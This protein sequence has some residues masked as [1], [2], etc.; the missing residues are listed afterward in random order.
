MR[1]ASRRLLSASRTYRY[2]VD[3]L[4][5]IHHDD[6][7]GS[8]T[9]ATAQ[10]DRKFLDSLYRGLRRRVDGIWSMRCAGEVNMVELAADIKR[11]G[12]DI[13]VFHSLVDGNK[14]AFAG[15]LTEPFEPRR[16]RYCHDTG[17]LY[18]ELSG[19][20]ERFG[21]LGLVGGHVVGHDLAERLIFYGASAT[22]VE[23]DWE[24]ARHRVAPL[25]DCVS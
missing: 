21:R 18:H 22:S 8:R 6:Q 25:V 20:N 9:L 13:V 5:Q 17:H 11:K 16:L 7:G 2:V 1:P 10:R 3:H 14:L 4:G 24:G 23:V 15:S 19:Y 12:D